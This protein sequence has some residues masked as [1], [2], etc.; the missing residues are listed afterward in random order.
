MSEMAAE[1]EEFEEKLIL[2]DNKETDSHNQRQRYGHTESTG[3]SEHPS[4]CLI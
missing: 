3:F 2:R 4:Q 1:E